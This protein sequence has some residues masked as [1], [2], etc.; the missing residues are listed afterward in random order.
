MQ[1][2]LKMRSWWCDNYV[3]SWWENYVY[4]CSRKSL[5]VNSN[6]YVCGSFW[7]TKRN[8]SREQ[9]AAN[10][11]HAMLRFRKQIENET[12]TPRLMR[13]IVPVCMSQYERTFNTTRIPGLERDRLVHRERANHVA[14]FWQGRW[15]ELRVQTWEGKMMSRAKLQAG[16]ERIVDSDEPPSSRDVQML[17]ALGRTEW[18]DFRERCLSEGRNRLSLDRIEKAAFTVVLCDEVKK[19]GTGWSERGNELLTGAGGRVWCDKS[20]N[21]VAFKDGDAG[22][23]VEHSWAD[24]LVSAHLWEWCVAEEVLMDRDETIMKMEQ[25]KKK[26][27][28]MLNDKNEDDDDDE[29]TKNI[30]LVSHLPFEVDSKIIEKARK[31]IIKETKHVDVEI[32]CV[33][34]CQR[35]RIKR[36]RISPDA[37]IQMAL[38]LAY[39]RDTNGQ[40]T[41]T[42]E[43]TATRL[44]RNGRTETVRVVTQ[45]SRNF[46]HVMTSKDSSREAVEKALRL[47]CSTHRENVKR[48][49]TGN[50]ID[51]HLFALYVAS[52][53]TNPDACTPDMLKIALE[54][55]GRWR[56]STSQQPQV[57]DVT[58][59][60]RVPQSERHKIASPGGGFGPAADDGYGVSYTWVEEGGLW[61]HVS[62]KRLGMS[63]RFGVEIQRAIKDMWDVLSE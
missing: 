63:K 20:L 41:L 40:F 24:A 56:L 28:D 42:Y 26:D 16:L 7:A 23:H 1:N 37:F 14:V 60:D 47:A 62:G 10:L 6:Y 36:S 58:Q 54:G 15:Y 57:Q 12:L 2:L 9:R 4:M 11:I 32:F 38:Q 49:V 19:K 31:Y 44:F 34:K 5:L 18:A 8:I 55:K 61:F 51:R 52:K 27:M 39:Y 17:T 25:E 33:E 13:G 43:A 3:T 22:L 29:R 46:V 50:G 48:S 45:D 35:D 30:V 59:R 53:M 21:L